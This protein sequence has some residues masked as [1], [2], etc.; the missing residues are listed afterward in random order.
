MTP[1]HNYS[2]QVDFCNLYISTNRAIA[3]ILLYVLAHEQRRPRCQKC[4][5]QHF[6]RYMGLR[7][8]AIY[9]PQEYFSW[10]I[11]FL[12]FFIAGRLPRGFP[13]KVNQSFLKLSLDDKWLCSTHGSLRCPSHT[14]FSSFT[15]TSSH[16]GPE[17]R[18]REMNGEM[19][20]QLRQWDG[21]DVNSV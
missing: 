17:E 11:L 18:E 13:G 19:K 9:F 10:L 2:R 8:S 12:G 4:I 20:K 14:S 7:A 15:F 1:I 5:A 3:T 16:P 6:A 21:C